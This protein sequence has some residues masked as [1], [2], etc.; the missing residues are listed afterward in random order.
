MSG[1]LDLAWQD[2]TRARAEEP[3]DIASLLLRG[4]ILEAR[5]TDAAPEQ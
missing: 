4:A 1:E 5:R 2:M 3:D